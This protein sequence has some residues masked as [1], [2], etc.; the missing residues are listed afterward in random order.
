MKSG[1]S[2]VDPAPVNDVAEPLGGH[3]ATDVVTPE[4]GT[5]DAAVDAPD[6]DE[7]DDVPALLLPHAAPSAT[8]AATDPRATTRLG[9]LIHAPFFGIN[10]SLDEVIPI[11]A[12]ICH[13]RPPG[14]TRD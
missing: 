9:N 3:I 14:L 13:D 1:A 6:V 5:A 12:D 2:K 7:D 4:V 8:S 10:L 11:W